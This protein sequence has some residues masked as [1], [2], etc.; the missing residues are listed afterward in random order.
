MNKVIK[1]TWLKALRSG[2]Y[3]QGKGQLREDETHFCCLGVLG[4]LLGIKWGK[5]YALGQAEHLGALPKHYSCGISCD[6][7]E[8]LGRLNDGGWGDKRKSFSQIA[9]YIEANL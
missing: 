6:Q 2:K 5:L 4:D 7:Q 9:D 1:K 8:K 3:K